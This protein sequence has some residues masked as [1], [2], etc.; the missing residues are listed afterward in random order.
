VSLID[1]GK[2]ESQ[3]LQS[4]DKLPILFHYNFEYDIPKESP[5]D[6]KTFSEPH[7]AIHIPGDAPQSIE[8]FGDENKNQPN[9]SYAHR[10]VTLEMS[11]D[12]YA[13]CNLNT[14]SGTRPIQF[15]FYDTVPYQSPINDIVNDDEKSQ[16][17]TTTTRQNEPLKRPLRVVDTLKTR[18]GLGVS[19]KPSGKKAAVKRANV[20]QRVVQK[21]K[22][23]SATRIPTQTSLLSHF[24]PKRRSAY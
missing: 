1:F 5:R 10:R 15:R 24:K 12:E 2:Y 3:S 6:D 19:V 13:D 22:N 17:S 4:P 14:S 8:V 7:T 23:R 11:N 9:S 21:Y 20:I 16:E 18:F